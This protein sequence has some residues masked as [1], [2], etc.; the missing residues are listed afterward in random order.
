M[1]DKSTHQGSLWYCFMDIMVNK[2]REA[3]AVVGDM[4]VVSIFLDMI[5]HVVLPGSPGCALCFHFVKLPFDY[6][7]AEKS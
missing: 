5:H 4:D 1:V 2:V 7:F 3:L 6:E